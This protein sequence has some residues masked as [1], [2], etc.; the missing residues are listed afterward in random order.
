[1][2]RTRIFLEDYIEE[3]YKSIGILTPRHLNIETISE[4]LG[5]TVMYMARSS[6]Q[7]GNTMVI[8][9]RLTDKEKWQVFCHELCHIQWHSV[10]QRVMNKL[11]LEYQ[12]W[13]AESFAMYACIPSFMLEQM[14]LPTNMKEVVWDIHETFNVELSFA[15]E[16]LE[17]WL[18]QREGHLFY[19]K[20]TRELSK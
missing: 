20:I 9:S 7:V 11:Y 19:Q 17:K 12:E 16:R 6:M 5:I 8:D 18:Q 15:E 4:R 1:M 2:N 10:N 14:D 13:K 3:M